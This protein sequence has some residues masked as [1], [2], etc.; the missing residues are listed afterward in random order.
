MPRPNSGVLIVRTPLG[1]RPNGVHSMPSMIQSARW[2]ARRL[3]I[4]EAN[5][6][7]RVW[8]KAH[9]QREFR[10]EWALSVWCCRRRAK[11]AKGGAQ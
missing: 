4:R 9:L 8:N 11:N 10:G 2:L 3:T 7:A 6:A 1:W 5:A